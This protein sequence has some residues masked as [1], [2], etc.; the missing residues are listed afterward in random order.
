MRWCAFLLHTAQ[1]Y[2]K[3][4]HWHLQLRLFLQSTSFSYN[5]ELTTNKL[6]DMK[7]IL[8][9]LILIMIFSEEK[10]QGLSFQDN[11]LNS[12]FPKDPGLVKVR[13]MNQTEK[14][15]INAKVLDFVG[16][17]EQYDYPAEEHNVTTNDGYNLIIHRIPG[18]PSVD[19][20]VNKEIVFLLHGI[21]GSSDSWVL[22]GPEKDLAFLLAD[23]GYDVWIGNVRGN[24]YCR[25]HVNMTTY[26]RK[27]WQYS[28][29][30]I[31]TKDLPAMFEYIF[32]YTDQKD[33]Y[34]IGHSM[35]TTSLFVLL[36]T[37]PEYNVKIKMAICLAPVAIWM[38]TSPVIHELSS[39]VPIV[40]FLAKHKIY[41]VIPQSLTTVTLAR[42]L[43]NDKV[44]TQSI[45]TTIIFSLTGADPAQLNTTS[46]PEVISH[47]PAGASV[48]AFEHYYQNVHTKDF[49]QYDYGIDENYRRYKRKT[50]PKYDLKKITAPIVM[51]Y[52]ENDFFVQE[53][54]VHELSKRLPNVVLTEKVPYKLFNHIDFTW[55]IDAKTLLFD[56][57]LELIQKF[58]TNKNISIK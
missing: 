11:F 38:K 13:R 7:S 31:G 35:G 45:C 58:E 6:T 53:Q 33:L 36:S 47:C 49:R 18:S 56:R 14:M 34:Y 26:D 57:V 20:K 39:I 50:P 2:E 27:F 40:K 32:R 51:F 48:Q 55:A 41:D 54:N 46:L 24:T 29:H 30:E 3:Y 37:K 52:A 15:T 44:I 22:Y 28:F 43:C 25:S 23:R 19:N 17:V 10:S 42:I 4:F 8:F 5:L 12:L 21:L 16:M 1:K 9:S